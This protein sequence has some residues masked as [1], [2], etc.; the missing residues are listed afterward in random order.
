MQLIVDVGS[1]QGAMGITRHQWQA[2]R[3]ACPRDDPRIAAAI[4]LGQPSQ[5]RSGGSKIIET[6]EGHALIG[7][8]G[9]D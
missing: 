9:R 3:S 7:L 6:I 2:G 1:I 4:H 5:F 8:P